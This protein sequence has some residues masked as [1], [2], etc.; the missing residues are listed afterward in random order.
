MLIQEMLQQI[1]SQLKEAQVATICSVNDLD[2]AVSFGN[3]A[4][5]DDPDVGQAGSD[6]QSGQA[7]RI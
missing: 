2:P 4:Q 6:H 5:V 1:Q 3:D 7:L